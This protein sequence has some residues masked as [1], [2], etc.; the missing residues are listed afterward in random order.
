MA[1]VAGLT[2]GTVALASLLG[3]CIDCMGYIDDGTHFGEDF[4]VSLIKLLL[5]QARL[6]AWGESVGATDIGNELPL[7]R[8]HWHRNV[9]IVGQSL[10]GIKKI[11][12]DSDTLEKKYGL[13]RVGTNRRIASDPS[14]SRTPSSAFSQ[15]QEVFQ[16]SI[17]ERQ[18]HTP[19]LRKTTWA[20]RDKKKF[21]SLITSLAFFI[22]NL[23][24]LSDRLH[25]LDLQK[26]ILES[27]VQQISNPDS[28]ILLEHASVQPEV[29]RVPTATTVTGPEETLTTT[30][31]TEGHTYLQNIIR[32]RAKAILGD[33]GDVGSN[34]RKHHYEYNET[35]GDAR[36][37]HGNASAAAA[38]NFLSS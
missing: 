15:I 23:E 38:L 16:T 7:L 4:E 33:I 14:A 31:Q 3:S 10:L 1:E 17:Q 8:A 36:A 37:I 18:K 2:I 22:D 24:K 20:I 35:S 21:E 32:D 34:A 13:Q 25:V 11:F 9:E 28:L 30:Q 19:L 12:D 29:S 26:H 5:L 27:R 6:E